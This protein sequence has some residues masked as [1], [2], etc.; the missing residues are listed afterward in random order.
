MDEILTK[1]AGQ[2]KSLGDNRIGGY[3]VV[4]SD[5]NSPDLVGDYFSKST[6]L[7]DLSDGDRVTT[8]WSHNLDKAVQG[9]I[10]RGHVKIDDS[11]IWYETQLAARQ[12]YE[13]RIKDIMRLV[14]EGKVGLSSG[15]PGHL[16]ARE[17]KGDVAHIKAW[18]VS[19]ASLCVTPC[20]PRCSVMPLK[21]LV[22]DMH[23]GDQKPNLTLADHSAKILADLDSYLVRIEGYAAMKTG[24]N[25]SISIERRTA[26]QTLQSRLD[27]VLKATAPKPDPELAR[28]K[29]RLI[30]EKLMQLPR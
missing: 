10:G 4:F 20:E 16:V 24:E 15:S 1:Y 21:S 18:M 12:E 3:L 6:D 30:K 14:D 23:Q 27:A 7:Y 8:L 29:I 13:D 22:L 28:M 5:E 25:R 26:F 19:E 2:V 11:G 9:P 17:Q